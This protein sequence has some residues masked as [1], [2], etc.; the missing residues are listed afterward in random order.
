MKQTGVKVLGTDPDQIDNAEDRHKFSSILDS[1]DV[2]QP[3]WTEVTSLDAAK[4]FAN[5]VGCVPFSS[6]LS[7]NMH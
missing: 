1:I 4:N 2:D 5:K 3:E 7:S 6:M